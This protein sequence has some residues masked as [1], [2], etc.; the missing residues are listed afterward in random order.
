[1]LSVAPVDD[2]PADDCASLVDYLAMEQEM[3]PIAPAAA[4]VPAAND[5]VALDQVIGDYYFGMGG[6]G[7]EEGGGGGA[8]SG[9]GSGAGSGSG[10]GA[11]SGSGSEGGGGEEDADPT[12]DE[13]HTNE[14]EGSITI[15]GQVS[16]DG[17]VGDLSVTLGGVASGSVTINPD[18]TFSVDIPTPTEPGD[19][20]IIVTD[21]NGNTTIYTIPYNP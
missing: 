19:I 1:V 17:D 10:S 13:V 7:E 16:D 21:A 11:G 12:I 9:S 4:E 18:G 15:D 5:P 8:G 2:V 14:V 6:E 20:I 3:G